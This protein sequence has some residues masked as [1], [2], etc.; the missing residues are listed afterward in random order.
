MDKGVYAWEICKSVRGKLKMDEGVYVNPEIERGGLA[1][2]W[3]L[4]L[5]VL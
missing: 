5:H 1:L 4:N 2:W 3:E